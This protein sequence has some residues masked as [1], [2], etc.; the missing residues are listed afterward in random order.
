[1]RE[2]G[3][4]TL[5]EAVP[6]LP[7]MDTVTSDTSKKLPGM[8]LAMV[9]ITWYPII[10]YAPKPV[11][12]ISHAPFNTSDVA[13]LNVGFTFSNCNTYSPSCARV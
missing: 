12:T 1:M 3:R 5:D 9:R 11:V 6:V 7:E 10:P 4:I 13:G 2:G 8:T